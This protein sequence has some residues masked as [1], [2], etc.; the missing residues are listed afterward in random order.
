MKLILLMIDTNTTNYIIDL[1][2]IAKKYKRYERYIK[3][4]EKKL[5]VILSQN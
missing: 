5:P 1:L 3:L 4:L 2:I